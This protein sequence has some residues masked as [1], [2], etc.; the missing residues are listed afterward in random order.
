MSNCMD[1]LKEYCEKWYQ[2]M[3]AVLLYKE[4]AVKFHELSYHAHQFV[5]Q[6][7]GS[8]SLNLCDLTVLSL[9]ESDLQS[10]SIPICCNVFQVSSLLISRYFSGN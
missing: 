9:F 4:P 5:K 2:A 7:G 6:Y 1:K 10:V 3:T 8:S